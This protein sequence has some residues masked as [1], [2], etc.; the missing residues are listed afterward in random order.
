MTKAKESWGSNLGLVLAMAGNAVGFGNF[1]RFPVQAISNGGGAFI[2]PYLV[3]FVLMGMPLLF[4]EWTTGRYGGQ[5]NDHST[6]FIMG[7]MG[8]RHGWRYIGVFGL[9]S[10]IVI[11]SY[12]CYMESWT[13]S[14]IYHS[15]VGTFS[16]MSQGEIAGFFSE[17]HNMGTTHSGIPY[18]NVLAFIVC[19]TLNVW[20][21]S[22]GLKGGIEV[23]A[24]IGVPLLILLGIFLAIRGI[25]IKP[26]EDGAI[27]AGIEGLKFL[28]TP[29]YTS[30]LDPK[31]WLAAAGQIFFTLSVGM[32]CIQCYSSYI[33]RNEDVA[34]GSFA[35][36]FTNEF[37]EIV[38]GGTVLLSISVGFFGIDTVQNMVANEGGLGIAFQS[39]PFL[40]QKWG[41]IMAMF[42]GIA[43]FGLLFIAGITS[44]LPMGSPFVSF[45]Q[46]EFKFKKRNA[47][48]A[49]GITILLCGLPTVFF[50]K[51]GVF[52]EYDYWGGTVGLFF[53]AMM[54]A[55]LFSWVFG[56]NKGWKEFTHAANM[57]V[58]VF[59]KYILKYVTPTMLIIIFLSALIKPANDNWSS[60]SIKGWKLDGSSILG[61]M[62]GKGDGI[63]NKWIA[64]TLYCEVEGTVS[65]IVAKSDGKYLNIL[66]KSSQ[67]SAEYG[68]TKSYP[69]KENNT[70]IAEIDSQVSVGTPIMTGHF[71]NNSLYVSLS[72]YFLLLLFVFGCTVVYIAAKRNHKNS[73]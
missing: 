52:D 70:V 42:C 17:Y 66:C 19:L 73:K 32:G 13:L 38:L 34:L 25:M 20:I 71:V 46:D 50:F 30:L 60:L 11:A 26:G 64:D 44:S 39:M 63:N 45:L 40:F 15:I 58:P 14:Y 16:N 2:I 43:F 57:K 55:I 33:D 62:M 59:F 3:C 31:V 67:N 68:Y 4:I 65:G 5:F 61:K 35:M 12:Y 51:R 49:F 48:L 72:R 18:E 54:E 37:V 69:V 10:S 24:K 1:L 21:L 29:Q 23:V 6:P 27:A 9:F 36:G 47:A 28:W 22:R 56:I 8:K 7:K 53:F 41:P